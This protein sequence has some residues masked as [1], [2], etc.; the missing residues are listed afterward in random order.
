MS[1]TIEDITEYHDIAITLIDPQNQ[2]KTLYLSKLYLAAYYPYF[3]NIFTEFPNADCISIPVRHIPTAKRLLYLAHYISN[4]A[5]VREIPKYLQNLYVAEL[6]VFFDKDY[7]NV[8]ELYNI[9]VPEEHFDVLY[10]VL[11]QMNMADDDKLL[12]VLHKN[13][14]PHFD[15]GTLDPNIAKR[16]REVKFYA[17][18]GDNNKYLI[19]NYLNSKTAYCNIDIGKMIFTQKNCLKKNL[20]A[21]CTNDGLQVM[22]LPSQK[23]KFVAHHNIKDT[24]RKENSQIII[25]DAGT[26]VALVNDETNIWNI[27]TSTKYS[28]NYKA[29]IVFSSDGKYI[30]VIHGTI[31]IL[32]CDF[33]LLYSVACDQSEFYVFMN[34]EPALIGCNTKSNKLNKI[35]FETNVVEEYMDHVNKNCPIANCFVSSND[36]LLCIEY[37]H[38]NIIINLK[39]KEQIRPSERY[40]SRTHFSSFSANNKKLLYFHFAD[41]IQS[42]DLFP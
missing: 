22:E 41:G 5:K 24:Y 13:L 39:T 27:E 38:F 34:N 28:L 12:D 21:Y 23:I 30:A 37:D 4:L 3:H 1:L 36:K 7:V 35:F 42:L 16:L 18:I 10:S 9:S 25:S 20:I 32:A 17:D 33:S 26:H 2:T 31:D 19:V 29:K 8:R 14:P 15:V 11:N 40:D 6:T